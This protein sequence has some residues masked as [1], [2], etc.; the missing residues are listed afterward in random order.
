MKA[1]EADAPF[2]YHSCTVTGGNGTSKNLVPDR[3]SATSVLVCFNYY[4]SSLED[5]WR[6]IK[7]RI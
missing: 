4:A 2:F 5:I 7:Y 6:E 3:G 1:L